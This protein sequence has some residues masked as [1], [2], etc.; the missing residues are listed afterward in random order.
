MAIAF[1]SFADQVEASSD[2]VRKME[3]YLLMAYFSLLMVI[4][5]SFHL[6]DEA[7]EIPMNQEAWKELAD[8]YCSLH[9][10]SASVSIQAYL[11]FLA[12]IK[13]LLSHHSLLNYHCFH[14]LPS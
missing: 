6:P 14:F 7:I 9:Y 4:L 2:F 13:Y 11:K 10:Y 1:A 12:S 8:S 5:S 3:Y